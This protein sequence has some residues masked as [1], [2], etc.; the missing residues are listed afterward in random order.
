VD[1]REQALTA[2]RGSYCPNGHG[3]LDH[4]GFCMHCSRIGVHYLIRDEDTVVCLYFAHLGDLGE[5][6]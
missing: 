6:L 1:W 5:A 4:N 2:I 3:S